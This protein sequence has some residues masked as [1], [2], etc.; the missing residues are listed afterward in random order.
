MSQPWAVIATAVLL[1]SCVVPLTSS[2]AIAQQATPIRMVPGGADDP[3]TAVR[4]FKPLTE[5]LAQELGRPVELVLR[6][7]YRETLDAFGRDEVDVVSGTAINFV[8]ARQRHG[9]RALVKRVA[10]D[11][12]TYTSIFVALASSAATRLE[13]LRGQRIAFSDPSSTS[14]YVLPRL[15]L[16]NIGVPDPATFF[17]E[18]K[19]KGNQYDAV[20]ALLA[21]EVEAAAVASFVLS[22]PGVEARRLRVLGRSEPVEMGPVFV[23]PRT[24]SPETIARLRAAFLAIGATPT[25]QSL[26]AAHQVWGFLPASDGDYEQT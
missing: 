10:A 5:H 22:D 13:D 4:R 25:M 15:M 17:A 6:A 3:V 12:T 19:F 24:L 7:S 23:N 14:G 18:I 20:R 8:Q 21:G 2:R 26:A 16:A 9:A 1:M 11:G